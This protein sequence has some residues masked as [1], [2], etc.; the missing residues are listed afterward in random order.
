[1]GKIKILGL[2]DFDFLEKDRI[3]QLVAEYYTKIERTLKGNLLILHLKK[4]NA[5]GS[6]AKIS[7]HARIENP[8]FVTLARA[9]D[10]D[11]N[12]ALHSVLKKLETEIEHK[13]KPKNKNP[14]HHKK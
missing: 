4:H 7:I 14:K 12:K 8:T 1:M 2:E 9:S 3:K 11:I 13:F 10:W 5:E 6:R